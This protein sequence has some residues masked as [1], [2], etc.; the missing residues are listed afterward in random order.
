MRDDERARRPQP[1]RTEPIRSFGGL[2][3]LSGPPGDPGGGGARGA[4]SLGDVV[5][6][7]VELGYRVVDEYVRQG[8]EAA[9][10]M[11][12]RTYGPEAAV[13]DAQQLT[14]RMVQYAS[15][16]MRLWFD[17]LQLGALGGLARPEPDR[18]LLREPT[19]TPAPELR[20][21]PARLRLELVSGRPAEV[22]LE[23]R[24]DA[25]VEHLVVHAL[26]AEG[27]DGRRLS[28]VAIRRAADEDAVVL[29]VA[30]P[31]DHPAGVYNGLIVDERTS[32][33]AGTVSV[34][35]GPAA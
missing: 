11:T 1:E 9:Q 2:F 25:P 22:S 8:Q 24:P 26:R 7:S 5:S 32:R 33:P 16:F 3:G 10:R 6:R 28:D 17:F 27:A 23:L 4:G 14:T 13:R 29:R 21:G 30:V 20:T 34:R 12:D 18:R 31:A 35:L 15:D 19:P